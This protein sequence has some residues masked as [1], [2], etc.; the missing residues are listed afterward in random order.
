MENKDIVKVMFSDGREQEV[1]LPLFGEVKLIMQNGKVYR[2]ET[3][4]IEN[5][6][7]K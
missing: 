7:K 5:L 6:N 1:E 4:E 2:K 3:K